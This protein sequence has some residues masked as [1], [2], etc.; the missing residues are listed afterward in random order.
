M[1]APTPSPERARLAAALQELRARTGLSMAALA[2]RTTFSKSSWERYLN[3]K[4]LPPRRAVQE[5]CRLAGEPDGRCLALWEIAESEWSGRAA[6]RARPDTQPQPPEP[7]PQARTTPPAPPPAPEEARR[8]G[9]TSTA[10][11]AVIASVCAL[12]VGGVATGLF[13][14]PRHDGEPPSTPSTTGPY[15][16]GSGCE[17]RDPIHMACAERP[18]TLASHHTATGA[19]LELRYSRPCGSSWA[20]M[21]GT[22]VGDRIE[23]TAGGPA[24]DAKV[25][26]DG[27]TETYVYTP[28]T[29]TAP[30]TVIRVC[31]RP[32]AGGGPECLDSRVR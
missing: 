11:V 8:T 16:R 10:V 31:F 22:R 32:A 7:E 28:M 2:E 12:T 29:S 15:C 30:G 25:K 3:G 17:G 18:A 13:L 6:E 5:L 24:R 26:D 14:L 23:M 1:T 21:W 19:W 4:S 27:E 20:R 9:V